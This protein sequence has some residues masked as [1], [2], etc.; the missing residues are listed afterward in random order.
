[1]SRNIRRSARGLAAVA[2]VLALCA[3]AFV[4]ITSATASASAR[5]TT[6]EVLGHF[7]CYQAREA[8]IK[9]PPNLL[10]E[11]A[12]Q[13]SPFAP[14]FGTTYLHCN[15]ANK[16]VPG[17]VYLTKHPLAHLFCMGI[18][19]PYAGA[20]VALSNQFGQAVMTVLTPTQL[21]LPSWKSNLGPPGVT[22]TA[23]P[24]LD[25]YTCYGL[26]AL[27]S[28]YAF[29]FPS[30]VKAEDEFSAPKYTAIRLGVA[31]RLCVPT[32]KINAGVSYP[33]ISAADPSL[34][35]FPSSATP[36]WKVVWDENQFGTAEV[37]PL[38]TGEEFCVPSTMQIK[39]A[40][41]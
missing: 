36:I 32:T 18:Q 35:C 38:T 34:T 20:T 24:G 19:Y 2:S 8:G 22:P 29:H 31:N 5:G 1:M 10:L 27:A 30:S 3:A 7:L 23:P 37:V 17:K 11:N 41:G 14:R 4:G 28:S 40:A 39:S 6:P 13:P 33:P 12:L 26:K 21:C 16:Q 9:P 15:P 25:H